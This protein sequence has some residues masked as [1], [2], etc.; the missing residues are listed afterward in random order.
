MRHLIE[1]LEGAM[2]PGRAAMVEGADTVKVTSL[3]KEAEKSADRMLALATWVKKMIPK[4]QMSERTEKFLAAQVAEIRAGA[5]A[6]TSV[7]AELK[8]LARGGAAS[9]ATMEGVDFQKYLGTD[10]VES[11]DSEREIEQYFSKKN[12]VHM[13]GPE[14]YDAHDAEAAKK[15]AIKAWNSMKDKE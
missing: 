4:M 10:G 15:A 14:E 9:S 12:L 6:A 5:S 8:T 2:A 3:I 13:F 7:A 11:F 1:R